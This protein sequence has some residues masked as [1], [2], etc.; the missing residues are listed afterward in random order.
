MVECLPF[1]LSVSTKTITRAVT[2]TNRNQSENLEES[3]KGLVEGLTVVALLCSIISLVPQ[4]GSLLSRNCGASNQSF[5]TS[6]SSIPRVALSVGLSLPG[7][8]F[9][10]SALHKV[11]ISST[12]FAQ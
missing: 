3:I 5:A 6:L 8:C 2:R 7:M 10:C 1:P 4:I 11:S 9:H 12:L